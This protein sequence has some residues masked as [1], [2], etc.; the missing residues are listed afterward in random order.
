MGFRHDPGLQFFCE[1]DCIGVI[2]H[3]QGGVQWRG[4]VMIVTRNDKPAPDPFLHKS[5][6]YGIRGQV[7][8]L[9]ERNVYFFLRQ[10]IRPEFIKAKLLDIDISRVK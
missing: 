6:F 8:M 2:A 1:E 10:L 5:P 9:D 7:K 4:S 3:H